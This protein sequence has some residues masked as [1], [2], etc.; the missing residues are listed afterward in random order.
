MLREGELTTVEQFNTVLKHLTDA[1]SE[2]IKTAVPLSKPTPF[3]KRWWSKDLGKSRRALQHLARASY[4]HHHICDHPSHSKYR[5]ARNRYGDE[6]KSAKQDHWEA[7]LKSADPDSIWMINHFTAAGPTDGSRPHVPPLKDGDAP[8]AKD[9]MAKSSVL[10][11]AFFPLPG[12]PPSLPSNH[13]YRKPAFHFS[14]ITDAQVEAVIK[15]LKELK[16]PGPDGR[17]F[18]ATFN[19]NVYPADWKMSNTAALRK[20][21]RPD[22]SV[23]KAYRP[24]ALLN[25][26]DSL[27]LLVKTVKDAWRQ[28][29][30]ASI[31]FLDIKAAFP[32]ANLECL[33]HNMHTR[34]VPKEIIN[35]LQRRLEG[36]HTRILFDDFKSA[37]FEIISSI[38]QGCPL[39]VI[40]Y[41][42]Y[43]SDLFEIAYRV[44]DSL[45]LGYIDDAAITAIGKNYTETHE[46]LRGYMDGEGGA[47]F[48][49]ND[50]QSE[51]SLDKFGLL[52]M[53]AMSPDVGPA[54]Q[55]QSANIKPLKA[56]KFLGITIDRHLHFQQQTAGALSKGFAWVQQ[57]RHLAR[58]SGGIPFSHMH[59]LYLSIAV[60]RILY[61][62]DIFLTPLRNLPGRKS[63]YGSVGAIKKLA[64][65]QRQATL[66]IT[67][68][69]RT[70]ASDVLDTHANLLPFAL[71]IDKNCHR[72]AVHLCTLPPS[73]PLHMHVKRLDPDQIETISPV[74][75]SPTWS[76]PF[77]VSVADNK[78]LALKDEAEWAAKHGFRVYS[79][80]SDIDEGVGAAAVLYKQGCAN[81]KVLQFHLGKS[82]EHTVYEAEDVGLILAVKLIHNE[83]VV[84]T[85]SCAGDNRASIQATR[86]SHPA[87][88]HTS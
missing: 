38:D 25:C 56:H 26:I 85:G 70:T 83:F 11:K 44:P 52:N 24:I 30:V 78:E 2:T 55:L 23:A 53:S 17:L 81:P 75:F 36:R 35:W 74:C 63:M 49:S 10:Y 67:G 88:S 8:L 68:A 9:N 57:F 76:P 20:L 60:P 54:L 37:L 12:P 13:R 48:W 73:H 3:T 7:W 51:F 15:K 4:R 79:D 28:K 18:H 43:N 62:A 39:S 16:A 77:Q 69:M 86:L 19:L 46:I 64:Q 29:K 82:L 41:E 65:V 45:A 66:F 50:H 1:I 42:F 87:P 47:T 32:S 59:H 31:L 33:F 84:Y 80:S 14:P 71:L 27:H 72:A 6:I 40:L 21:G 22:Y 61:A 34:G 58:A 5:K